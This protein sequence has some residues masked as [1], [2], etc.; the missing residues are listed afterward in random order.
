MKDDV[1]QFQHKHFI[2]LAFSLAFVLPALL[3]WVG[4]G[5]FLGGVLYGGFLVRLLIWHCVFSINSLAHK[6]GSQEYSRDISARGNWLLALITCGEGHHNFHH[7]FPNDY[8]NGIMWYDYDPTKWA[9]LLACKL[10]WA[11]HPK[12][13]SSDLIAHAKWQTLD[14]DSVKPALKC[15][16]MTR[17]DFD[18]RCHKGEA[19]IIIDGWVINIEP[20][21]DHHPGG[22]NILRE[23]I[24][25]DA[26]WAFS[27]GI[28][29]HSQA[30]RLVAMNHR[31]AKLC[32]N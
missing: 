6:F 12:T 13:T 21:I 19:L 3:A 14:S 22:Q 7:E 10:Q 20:Y 29:H 30:A 9:I 23:Y 27:G 28:N 25:N 17:K 24:G 26:T 18:L 2:P 16:K 1:V 4:W 11:K 32:D 8:R 5:D 31:I 15:P